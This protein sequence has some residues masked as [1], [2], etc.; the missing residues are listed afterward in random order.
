MAPCIHPP[1]K[2]WDSWAAG[3]SKAAASKTTFKGELEFLNDL[4]YKLGKE[5]LIFQ[6]RHELFDSGT[7]NYCKYGHLYDNP[8]KIVV[9]TTLQPRMLESAEN[10]L[11]GFFGLYWTKHANILATIDHATTGE[12]ACTNEAT[13]M[14]TTIAEPVSTWQKSYV[15]QRTEK[16]KLLL[17]ITAGP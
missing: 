1:P 2:G 10:F 17:E 12:F 6:G 16:L 13:S 8:S 9:R 7:L 3:I 4:S 14:L 15:K 11:A 5:I